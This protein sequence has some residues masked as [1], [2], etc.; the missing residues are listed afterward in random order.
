ML[1]V[2]SA[3]DGSEAV[4]LAGKLLPDV[5]ILDVRMPGMDGMRALSAIREA[6]PDTRVIMFTSDASKRIIREAIRAGAHALLLKRSA[7][8]LSAAVRRVLAGERFV[9]ACALEEAFGPAGAPGK[10]LI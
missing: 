1:V 6:A 3:A 5:V 2:A 7:A 8:Q 10:S 4:R 9:D